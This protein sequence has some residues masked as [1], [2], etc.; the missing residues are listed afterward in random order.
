MFWPFCTMPAIPVSGRKRGNPAGCADRKEA[1]QSA[2]DSHSLQIVKSNNQSVSMKNF[3][4]TNYN[5][6]SQLFLNRWIGKD[7]VICVKQRHVRKDEHLVFYHGEKEIRICILT[8][9]ESKNDGACFFG[10]LKHLAKMM[11]CHVYGYALQDICY[12]PDIQPMKRIETA[13][14][15]YIKI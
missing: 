9:K 7:K 1:H 15:N 11:Y 5:E 3:D 10:N 14:N 13:I 6:A 2:D 4:I 12:R 8:L